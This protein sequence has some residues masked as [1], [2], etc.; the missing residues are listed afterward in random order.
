MVFL[1]EIV[2]FLLAF[3]IVFLFIEIH[4]YLERARIV[5][6]IENEMET[7]ERNLSINKYWTDIDGKRYIQVEEINYIA[8]D[9]D[10]GVTDVNEKKEKLETKTNDNEEFEI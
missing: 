1:I 6:A 7:D 5:L 2:F 10:D 8:N 4:R 3:E 9:D